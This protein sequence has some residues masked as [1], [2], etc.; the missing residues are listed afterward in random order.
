MLAALGLFVFDLPTAL[1]D[2][3]ERRSDWRHT[4][5]PRFGARPAS[6]YVGPGPDTINLRGALVPEIAGR[7]AALETLRTMADDGEAWPLVDGA[8][9]VFGNFVIVAL[10]ER[11]GWFVDNGVP[12][13][14]DFNLQLERDD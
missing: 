2:E 12:R 11:Q 8:G 3:L 14:I 6:Q 13:R 10:D 4:S 1:F 7:Q 9:R 5:V